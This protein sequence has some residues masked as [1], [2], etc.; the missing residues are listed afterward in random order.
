MW[1][2]NKSSAAS[3]CLREFSWAVT[4]RLIGCRWLPYISW[5]LV[6]HL[7]GDQLLETMDMQ[8]EL[9][10]LQ[11]DRSLV[12]DPAKQADWASKKLVWVPNEE[13]GFV[14][15]SIKGE[16][17]E[18]YVVE[19]KDTNKQMRV[20][21][22]DVQKMNPP[23]FSKVEDMAELTCLNEASV[24]HNLKERYYAGMIYVRFLHFFIV[25]LFFDNKSEYLSCEFL[26]AF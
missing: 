1:L 16:K 15:A 26:P 6:T 18:E 11:V 25:Q 2:N 7:S 14:E 23:K 17:N 9:K 19:I 20:Y 12:T 24:L 4:T 21:K 13:H 5:R 10:Y 3:V 22:D 8:E